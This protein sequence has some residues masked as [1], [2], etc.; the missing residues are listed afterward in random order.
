MNG[1]SFLLHPGAA[2][3]ILDIWTYIAND[4]VGAASRVR[5][6]ILEAIRKLTPLPH[7]GHRRPDLTSR[8]LRFWRARDF[9]IAYAPDEKPLWIVGVLYGRRDPRVLA[10]IPRSREG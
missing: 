9:L 7:Q 6:E 3:D 2:Q 4:N 1:P 8:P 5:E 10:A